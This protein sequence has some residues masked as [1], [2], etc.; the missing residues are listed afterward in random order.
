MRRN[1]AAVWRIAPS[2]LTTPH[3]STTQ[4]R[5]IGRGADHRLKHALPVG[6]IAPGEAALDAAMAAIGLA[7]FPRHHAHDLLALHLRL[8]GAADPA[9]SAGRDLRGLGKPDLANRFFLQR[10]GRAGLDAGAA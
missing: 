8:E 6:R 4:G 1:S 10:S 3:G 5:V 2:P 9:I 7:V